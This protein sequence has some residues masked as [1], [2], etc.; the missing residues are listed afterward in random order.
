MQR[1][2]VRM[3]SSV[4]VATLLVSI[5]FGI[6]WAKELAPDFVELAKKLKPSVVNI[7]TAKTVKP[8]TQ[9]RRPFNTPFGNDPFQD[10]F[11]R[12]FDNMQPRQYKQRSLGSGFIIDGGYILTNNHVVNGADEIKIK[13]ADGREFKAEVKGLDE[14]LD[15]ALLK[16]DAKEELPT[17]KMGDSDAIEVGEWVMAI[18]NPFGLA[19]TVTAGIVSAKGRVIGSGPYDDFIQTD[20]SINPGNSGG[21]LFN[22]KG[23][24]IGINTAIIAG[25]QGIGFAIPINM[26]KSIIPQLR[27]KGKV[28]RGWLGVSIQPVTP[29]LAKSFGLSSEKGAL[30]SEVLPE[31]PA[32]KA[33]LK[34]GDIILEFDGKAIH[35]MSELPRVVAATDVGKKVTIKIVR[36]GKEEEVTTVIDRLKDGGGE[37]RGEA[38]QDKLGLT[39][40]ELNK[41][42][43][44][45]FQLKDTTGVVVTEV[46]PDGLAQEAGIAQ[47]DVIKEIDGKKVTNPKKYEKAIAAH[48]KGQIV[49]F[50]LKRG[51]SSLFVAAKLD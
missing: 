11:D 46:K 17:A 22:A 36:D 32:E 7:S 16:T 39:V 40:R 3:F 41:E 5:G 23:E 9:F 38:A 43:A 8:Q 24:V 1:T 34:P 21:P 15:L 26:A 20:A 29:D 6:T 30:V 2:A 25:G 35:E 49:R 44:S 18:G 50:L 12:F 14:K 31:S 28:T 4:M 27:D 33:E 47:G 37:E 51:D 13:L 45:R 19:E 48:K 10:F 42:L